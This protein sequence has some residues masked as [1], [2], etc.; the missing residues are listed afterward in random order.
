MT[1]EGRDRQ[2]GGV[3]NELRLHVSGAPHNNEQRKER[4]RHA[5]RQ[6]LETND[7]SESEEY[8]PPDIDHPPR[9]MMV[10]AITSRHWKQTIFGG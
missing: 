8:V 5:D 1:H 10:L 3:V 2:G 7:N 9:D 6:S 4:D